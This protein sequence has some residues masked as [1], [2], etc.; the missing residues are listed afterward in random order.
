V[1]IVKKL[2]RGC[3]IMKMAGVIVVRAT[4]TTVRVQ[5]KG[6]VAATIIATMIIKVAHF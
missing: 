6:I 2:I 3:R 5:D 4:G 1:G